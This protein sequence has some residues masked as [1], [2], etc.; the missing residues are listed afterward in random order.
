[1]GSLHGLSVPLKPRRAPRVR[2]RISRRPRDAS[3]LEGPPLQAVSRSVVLCLSLTATTSMS[4]AA[5]IGQ[6][7]ER[8]EEDFRATAESLVRK[9]YL[10]SRDGMESRR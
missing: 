7:V 4:P 10:E 2:G 9:A 8:L 5:L 3:P 6:A 1:M